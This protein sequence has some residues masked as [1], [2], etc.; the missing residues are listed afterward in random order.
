M[1]CL[2]T[3]KYIGVDTGVNTFEDTGKSKENEVVASNDTDVDT[4][5][6]TKSGRITEHKKNIH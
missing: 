5:K 3:I 1:P 4:L 6:V 2:H